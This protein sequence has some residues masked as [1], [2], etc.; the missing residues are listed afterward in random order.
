MKT[1]RTLTGG[2]LARY[3]FVHVTGL[4]TRRGIEDE[5]IIWARPDQYGRYEGNNGMEVA[6]TVDGEVWLRS[7][8][9][10]KTEDPSVLETLKKLCPNGTGAFV[11]CSN[12]E[13][14]PS[15]MVLERISDPLSDHYGLYSPEIRQ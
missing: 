11:P 1:E 3:G 6:I 14:I 13:A 5:Q 4:P 7:V 12:G 2:E 15:H 8:P 10:R 9:N